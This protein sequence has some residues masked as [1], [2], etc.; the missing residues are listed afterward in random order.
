MFNKKFGL[1]PPKKDG[2]MGIFKDSVCLVLICILLFSLFFGMLWVASEESK[3]NSME[4]ICK[5][6][7]F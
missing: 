1:T 7:H 3:P 6:S 2:F 4:E 5:E